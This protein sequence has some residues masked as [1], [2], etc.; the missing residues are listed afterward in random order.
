MTAAFDELA[1]ELRR[2]ALTFELEPLDSSRV[3]VLSP[4]TFDDGDRYPLVIEQ[5]GDHWRL[6]D[7]GG[8]AMHLSYA[9]VAF[10]KGNRARLIAAVA[11]RHGLSVEDWELTRELS[12]PPRA[13]D[14][15]DFL[16]ALVRVNDVEFLGREIVASTFAEDVRSFFGERVDPRVL[17]F[18]HVLAEHDPSG[19]YRIDVAIE[20]AARPPLFVFAPG[21][22]AKVRDATITLLT[23]Q[24][25]G[26]R[27]ESVAVFEDQQEV[28]RA[29]L[30]RL[31]DVVGKQFATLRGNEERITRFLAD[32]DVPLAAGPGMGA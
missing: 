20:R 6:S 4:F 9:D 3:A 12:H 15:L 21:T 17:R 5:S 27:H 32:S 25:W 22:D 29:P 14:V 13:A 16:H 26:V 24:G 31:S 2:T 1:S 28:G 18:D 10:D 7:E 23:V 19:L 11:L 8:G 30:A